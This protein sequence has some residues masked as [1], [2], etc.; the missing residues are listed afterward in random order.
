MFINNVFYVDTRQ[1][2]RDIT[3]VVRRFAEQRGMGRFPVRDMCRVTV[4]ELQIRLAYP[5]VTNWKEELSLF[6]AY[7]NPLTA[8]QL[9]YYSCH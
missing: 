9:H 3:A 7:I 4:G 2:C 1:D 6:E 5:E 8:H